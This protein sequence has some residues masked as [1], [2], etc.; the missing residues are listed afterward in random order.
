MW[1]I[2]NTNHYFFSCVKYAKA[3]DELF[4]NFFNICNLNIL[5]TH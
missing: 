1:K 3:R 5:N 2:E 4:N